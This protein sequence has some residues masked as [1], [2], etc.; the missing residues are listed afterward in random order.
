VSVVVVSYNTCEQLRRCL[1][2]VEPEHQ[3][4]V[5]DNGSTDGSPEMVRDDFPH[6]TLIAN[7]ENRGFGPANNQGSRVASGDLILY[8]NSDAYAA[9]GAIA[10]L[11]CAFDDASVAAAG[12]RLLNP[13]GTLQ[14]S[15]ANELTL[16]AVFCEQSYLEKLLPR[17]RLFSPYWNTRR[18]LESAEP[19]P[20]TPQVMGACL[21]S[22]R[23]LEEFDERFFLYVEDTDL[24][25]R[26]RGHG[27]IV[28]V[29]EAEFVHELGSSASAERWRSVARYNRGKELYFRLH[30]GPAASAACRALNRL[31]ALARTLFWGAAAVVTLGLVGRLRRQAALHARVL[32]AR[33]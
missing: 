31:G 15:T 4:V 12:G 9:P 27:R 8:L 10:R 28:Y 25:R 6:A 2:C 14:P 20:E 18:L 11:A 5:V 13:D 19:A 33:I 23:G 32:L 1:S 26:L 24:C 30:H 21:M 16:W 3:I 17:S 22:R 7:G 29:P